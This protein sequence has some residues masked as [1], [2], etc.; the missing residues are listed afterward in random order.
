[1]AVTDNRGGSSK[2]PRILPLAEGY[3]R[4]GGLN[5]KTSQV[6]E[7]PPLPSGIKPA[8]NSGTPDKKK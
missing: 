6:R 1:V 4:K 5:P 8:S 3:T 2:G 7:R